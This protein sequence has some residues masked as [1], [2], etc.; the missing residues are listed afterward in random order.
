MSGQL[1]EQRAFS[2]EE[3]SA[4][5][6]VGRSTV[7][8]LLEEGELG[9]KK[10]GGSYR[11]FLSDLEDYL[12]KDR[13]R[14]LIRDLTGEG[15]VGHGPEG[16]HKS[17]QKSKFEPVAQ[18]WEEIGE[19][20]A[21]VLS[22]LSKTDVQDLRSLLYRRFGKESLIVRSVEQGRSR[23]VEQED[24]RWVRKEAGTGSGRTFKA[25]VR[26]RMDD[27]YLRH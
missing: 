14:S 1:P 8:S 27:S 26:S 21:I 15:T 22:G 12:G 2:P 4:M 20:E 3:V 7:L 13:A 17:A 23:F 10:I 16:G 6:G 25:L 18:K 9:S 24:G 5:L 11:I 19:D